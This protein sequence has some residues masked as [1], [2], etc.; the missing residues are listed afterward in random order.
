MAELALNHVQ[1]DPGRRHARGVAVPEP[2]GV[3]PLLNPRPGRAPSQHLPHARL[4]DGPPDAVLR[5]LTEERSGAVQAEASSVA[6]P[7]PDDLAQADLDR[8]RPGLAALSLVDFDRSDVP[9]WQ[10]NCATHRSL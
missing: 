6:R 10:A 3:D 7:L 2:A 9:S 1:R 4:G 5:D 8:R